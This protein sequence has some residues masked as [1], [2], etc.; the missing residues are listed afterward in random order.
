MTDRWQP[1]GMAAG[2][3]VQLVRVQQLRRIEVLGHL[4]GGLAA[5]PEQRLLLVH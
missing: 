3:G 1:G 4:G 5:A 2:G